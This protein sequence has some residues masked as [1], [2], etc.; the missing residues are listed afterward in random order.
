MKKDPDYKIVDILARKDRQDEF[1]KTVPEPND[2][3]LKL[4]DDGWKIDQAVSWGHN[5]YMIKY[6]LV[7]SNIARN[8]YG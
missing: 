1:D 4:L 5:N 6:I 8:L 3:L 7:R 2:E